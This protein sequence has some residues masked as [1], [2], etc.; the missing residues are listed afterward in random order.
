MK[1]LVIVIAICA[2]ILTPNL[3]ISAS[4]RS[5]RFGVLSPPNQDLDSRSTYKGALPPPE[6]T[7]SKPPQKKASQPS[8]S[9][10][11]ETHTITDILNAMKEQNADNEKLH[12]LFTKML[13]SITGP[14]DIFKKYALNS[15]H[16][17]WGRFFLQNPDHIYKTNYT[18]IAT[19]IPQWIENIKKEEQINTNMKELRNAIS[20]R[21]ELL[22]VVDKAISWHLLRQ[23]DSRFGTIHA[24]RTKIDNA[25]DLREMIE[26]QIYIKTMIIEI[27]NEMTRLQTIAHLSNAERTL[28]E[29]QKR[30]YNIKIFGHKNKEMPQ[31]RNTKPI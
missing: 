10:K 15:W 29:Q 7:K 17:E 27:Q 16:S 1:Q 3:E 19:E 2:F 30:Q 5:S 28:R 23:A 4:H 11:T 20:V 18:Q 31:I 14:R 13:T 25:S 24:I 9:V 12:D 6:P 8:N 22:G 26:L 21:S